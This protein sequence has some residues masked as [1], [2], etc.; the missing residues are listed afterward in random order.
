MLHV[1]ETALDGGLRWFGVD[2]YLHRD[3]GRSGLIVTFFEMPAEIGTLRPCDIVFVNAGLVM[4]L[5]WLHIPTLATDQTRLQLNMMN[6]F[7]GVSFSPG[8][9]ASSSDALPFERLA[10]R[11]LTGISARIPCS[12]ILMFHSVSE[13]HACE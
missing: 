2:V 12:C 13:A 5:T 11:W 3:W 10:R 7:L 9:C 1:F 4:L 8:V 6:T